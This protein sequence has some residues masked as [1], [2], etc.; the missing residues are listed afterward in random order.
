[1][2]F[3]RALASSVRSV[4]LG[5]E[6]RPPVVDRHRLQAQDLDGLL[7]CMRSGSTGRFPVTCSI[8]GSGYFGLF[9]GLRL[10]NAHPATMSLVGLVR[11]SGAMD[12]TAGAIRQVALGGRCSIFVPDKFPPQWRWCSKCCLPQ[13]DSFPFMCLG[14]CQDPFNH[15][16]HTLPNMASPRSGTCNGHSKSSGAPNTLLR[17]PSRPATLCVIPENVETAT[18]PSSD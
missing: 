11:S 18:K 2:D 3:S 7:G 17:Q 6:L 10:P 14:S 15:I 1:M 8:G 13:L 4:C 9:G 16:R 5:F 12:L